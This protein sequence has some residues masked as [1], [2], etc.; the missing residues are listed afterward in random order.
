MEYSKKFVLIPEDRVQVTEHLSEMDQQMKSI[1]QSKELTDSEKATL[2]L[3]ILQKYT[4]FSTH[5]VNDMSEESAP[6]AE[7]V[8]KQEDDVEENTINMVP[9]RYKN[10]A[11]DILEYLRGHTLLEWN[12][13]GEIIYKGEIIPHTNI[14]YLINELL[15][16]KKKQ[17]VKG[18]DVFINILGNIQFPMHLDVNKK[19]YK[20]ENN[21]K[22]HFGNGKNVM[23]PIMYARKNTWL[24]F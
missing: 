17:S 22:N 7:P 4:N 14:A 3:Q 16:N 6:I 2:Y 1:L 13:K 5:K 8:V 21:A 11:K 24:T 19:L 15:R 18:F 12:S 10:I 9:V 23:K 20:N